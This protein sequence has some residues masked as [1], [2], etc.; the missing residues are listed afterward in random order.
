MPL[1]MNQQD[2]NHNR[3]GQWVNTT[4]SGNILQLSHPLNS[5]APVGSYTIVVWIGEEKIYHNFKVEQYGR[6][7]FSFMLGNVASMHHNPG[8]LWSWLLFFLSVVLPKFEIKMNLTDKISVVQE[9]YEVK[10]C[11]E[12]VN[13]IGDL[14]CTVVT[15][16]CVTPLHV[17]NDLITWRQTWVELLLE[18]FNLFTVI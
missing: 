11:A 9:E 6:L 7:S 17:I 12:W 5:E 1:P 14:Q 8:T 13:T 4:S 2:V 10:V 3:I 16:W 18:V 15:R